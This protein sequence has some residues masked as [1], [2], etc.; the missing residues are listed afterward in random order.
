MI[1]NEA[2]DEKNKII[3]K[4]NNNNKNKRRGAICEKTEQEKN[5]KKFETTQTELNC[6]FY[7]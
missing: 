4:E 6:K 7:S 3:M 1:E 5:I 2:N